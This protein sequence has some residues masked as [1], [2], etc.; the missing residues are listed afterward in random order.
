[1]KNEHKTFLICSYVDILAT[2]DNRIN[3]ALPQI[4]G[5]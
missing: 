4:S 2:A 3:A 1:M 5:Q